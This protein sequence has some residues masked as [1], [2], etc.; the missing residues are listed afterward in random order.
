MYDVIDHSRRAGGKK[1]SMRGFIK[2]K[3]A[4]LYIDLLRRRMIKG[5]FS[6]WYREQ[7]SP[8]MERTYIVDRVTI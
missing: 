3:E 2:K 7:T 6:I 1:Y 4:E 8:I 5:D